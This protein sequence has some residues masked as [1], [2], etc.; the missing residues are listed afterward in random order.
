VWLRGD[1]ATYQTSFSWVDR[2]S[3]S[4][5]HQTSFSGVIGLDTGNHKERREINK[6][7][8]Q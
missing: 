7:L 6:Q 8:S 5:V 2:T 3:F 1:A 4:A